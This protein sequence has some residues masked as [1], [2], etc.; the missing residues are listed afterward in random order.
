M[1]LISSSSLLSSSS[2]P[3][4]TAL[5]LRELRELDTEEPEFG[6]RSLTSQLPD[7]AD[8][9]TDSTTVNEGASTSNAAGD[10]G[11]NQFKRIGKIKFRKRIRQRNSSSESDGWRSWMNCYHRYLESSEGLCIMFGAVIWMS[12]HIFGTQH[13]HVLTLVTIQ[14]EQYMH[15]ECV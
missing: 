7:S 11:S 6:E 8:V 12:M 3:S 10:A 2:Q 14:I 1:W 5:A 13:M 9:V 15:N 4:S